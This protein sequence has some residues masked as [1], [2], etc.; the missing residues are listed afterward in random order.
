MQ[1]VMETI[2]VYP[3]KMEFPVMEDFGVAPPPIG[4]LEITVSHFH[5]DSVSYP[6]RC[7]GH[8]DTCVGASRCMATQLTTAQQAALPARV[9]GA[10]V[11]CLA[12]PADHQGGWVAKQRSDWQ[13]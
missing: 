5:T 9:V 3:N 8:A 11:L 2:I 6:C 12:L 13:V 7:A 4:M 10:E 1:M